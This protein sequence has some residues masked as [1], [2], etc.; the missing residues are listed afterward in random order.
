MAYFPFATSIESRYSLVAT[1]GSTA[2]FN[3][4]LDP[5]Y[6]GALT[7]VTGLDS[8][9]VRESAFDLTESDGGSHGAFYLGRRPI[10]LNGLVY[11]HTSVVERETRL[12]RARRASLA[13]RGDSTL[14]W[15]PRSRVENIVTNPRAQTNTTDWYTSGATVSSGATL[16]RVTGVAPPVGTTGFQIVTTGSGNTNQGAGHTVTLV[17]GTTY[18]ISAAYRRTAGTGTGEVIIAGVSGGNS[19]TIASGLTASGWTTVSNT[20]VPTV[21]GSYSLA[22]RQPSSNTL[23]STFQ[24]SDVMVSPGT[25]LTYRDGDTSGWMWNG[26]V[27]NSTSGD[28]LDMFVP[29]RRQQPFRESGAWNKTFQIALVSQYATIFGSSLKT[30]TL[31]SATENRGN[32]PA[33]P[34][35]NITGAS[36]NPTVSDGTRV[37]RTTGLTLAGG[38]VV[39]FD[40]LNHTG[41]FTAGARVGQSANRY[42][43]F[44]LTAWP[45][46]T[47]LGTT[48]TFT[49]AGGGSGNTQYR[50]TWA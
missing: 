31:G 46:V 50:D 28:Y 29:V 48:Q 14:S 25:T 27:G 33:Y 3:D 37:F 22:F 18:A 41:I 36:T 49:L 15:R 19:G 17:A 11:G 26:D 8:A 44:T 43:D 45:Y 4:P 35:I 10:I 2:V 12:D 42:I 6:V 34:L 21:S 38:E 1:D 32:Y 47:G 23:A 24:F 40:M 13:L 39:Q 20:F 5:N 30:V 16:T 9:E 7:E